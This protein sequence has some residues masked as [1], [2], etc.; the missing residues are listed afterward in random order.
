LVAISHGLTNGGMTRLSSSPRPT[1]RF[2]EHNATARCVPTPRRG[3]GRRSL[4]D[5]APRAIGRGTRIAMTRR[6]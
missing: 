4:W 5:R 2:C 1:V 3:R 6:A